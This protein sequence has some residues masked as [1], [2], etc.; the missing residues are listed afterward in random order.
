MMKNM[1]NKQYGIG[2]LGWISI[3]G[4]L[5]FF[6]LIGL[7]VF[8]LYSE[9][10]TVL[11]AMESVANRPDI[12]TMTSKQIRTSL[13]KNIEIS[14]NSERFSNEKLLKNLVFIEK[15]K[16]TKK[17]YIHIIYEGRN[18]F[19]KDLEFVLLFDHRL[20]LGSSGGE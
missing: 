18:K 10:L 20:E 4:V 2:A 11:T 14:S 3:L 7:R 13:R 16:K 19:V 5:A 17:K 1:K 9:K 6:V 12:K 8:P 15:D